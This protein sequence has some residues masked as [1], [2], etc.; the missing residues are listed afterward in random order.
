MTELV[1]LEYQTDL[2]ASIDDPT[3]DRF[4]KVFEALNALLGGVTD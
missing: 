1:F 3:R 4:E 2:L